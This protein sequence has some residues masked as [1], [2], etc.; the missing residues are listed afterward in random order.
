[1]LRAKIYGHK[2]NAIALKPVVFLLGC[3]GAA[4]AL[5]AGLCIYMYRVTSR[6]A[7]RSSACARAY[8]Y[9]L[10]NRKARNKARND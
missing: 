6:R 10:V 5:L 8:T 3:I 4:A 9:V 2:L 7:L 1:M